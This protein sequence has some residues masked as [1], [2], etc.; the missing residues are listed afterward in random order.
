MRILHIGDFHFRSDKNIYE[1]EKVIEGLFS[2][3]EN[4]EKIDFV[5]FTGDLVNS[6][7]SIED[8][9]KADDLLFKPFTEKLNISRDRLFI[10]PGNHDLNRDE[11]S[12]S[13]FNYL[14]NQVS[15]NYS[16]DSFYLKKSKDFKTS[17]DPFKNY[18]EY[19]EKY[20][21]LSSCQNSDLHFVYEV[22]YEDIKFGIVTINTAWLSSGSR[23]D[24]RD[25]LN[26][27]LFPETLIK[28]AVQRIK[29]CHI[30]ILLLHH[31]LTH[32]KEFNYVA[33]Q[34]IIHSEFDMMFSGHVHREEIKTEYK[35]SDNGIFCNTTQATLSFDGGFIGYSV[36]NFDIEDI[37]TLTLERFRY[38]SDINSFVDIDRVV[39]S[40]PQNEEKYRQNRLR[41]KITSKF[42]E[43]LNKANK[44]LLDYEVMY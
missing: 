34:N 10:C 6:G 27:L 21:P 11:C 31:P 40:V 17:L 25:D 8:F 39:I 3:L 37:S 20:F 26:K 42:S 32:L 44:L 35:S 15:D 24:L 43:E 36:I 4:S 18:R 1:Q 14:D 5:F 23:Q 13:V 16:L 41:K 33:L 28:E 2:K 7:H 29:Q 9:K 22:P 12:I 38:L 19:F 30:K